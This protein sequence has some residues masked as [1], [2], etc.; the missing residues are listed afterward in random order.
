MSRAMSSSGLPAGAQLGQAER[1]VVE[2]CSFCGQPVGKW[3]FRVNGAMSCMSCA[4]AAKNAASKDTH[5]TFVR[6]LLFG[7][8]AALLGLVL[9]TTFG[10]LIGVVAGYLSLGVGYLVGKIMMIG[11]GGVG[12]RRYQV[13]AALLTYAAVTLS[14]VPISVGYQIRHTPA[15]LRQMPWQM[16]GGE[17]AAQVA[18]ADRQLQQEF[19]NAAARPLPAQRAG[20]KPT[21]A[22]G[23]G[24]A[25]NETNITEHAKVSG[26][27]RP[28]QNLAA[29]VGYVVLIGLASPLLEL[30]D[31][32]HG[33]IGL[34][35]L[36]AGIFIA[37]RV[38]DAK[39]VEIVGPFEGIG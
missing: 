3:Y 31:P 11:S 37:W 20:A 10:I 27:V 35:I 25:A 19:G 22:P 4:Q 17:K 1:V 32:V 14:A 9:Y 24:S 18:D 21:G 5:A 38:T 28:R 34:I 36:L 39:P 12:G 29:A 2:A 30:Q 15:A 7:C 26:G 8:G 33:I 16:S 13:T 23:S 6:A